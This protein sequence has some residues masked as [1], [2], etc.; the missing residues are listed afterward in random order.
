MQDGD[1]QDEDMDEKNAAPRPAAP[2]GEENV[3][4]DVG[5]FTALLGGAVRV[6]TSAGPVRVTV[7]AGTSSGARFRLSGKGAP[8]LNGRVRDLVAE[9]RIVVPKN[10]D[11]QSRELLERVRGLN[12]EKE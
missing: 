10:L 3:R 12:P 1:L 7:P 8:D 5:V 11:G 9:V 2:V 6:A 4:V